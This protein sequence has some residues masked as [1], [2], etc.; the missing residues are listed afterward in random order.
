MSFGVSTTSTFDVRDVAVDAQL[1]PL[2]G[3]DVQVGGVALDHLLEQR[4]Q[5][6]GV[7]GG[8]G[9]V[10]PA[11]VAVSGATGYPL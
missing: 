6:D 3:G 7:G 2:A 4:A 1:G 9:H 5:V 10:T 11:E 8:C